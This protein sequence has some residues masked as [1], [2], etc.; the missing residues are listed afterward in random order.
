MVEDKFVQALILTEFDLKKGAVVRF[1]YPKPL[2]GVN[3]ELLASYMMPDGV[4]NKKSDVIYFMLNRRPFKDLK[5]HLPA[6]KSASPSQPVDLAA[7]AGIAQVR[8][9]F[10]PV[11]VYSLF[12]QTNGKLRRMCRVAHAWK[13]D[14]G[15][16]RKQGCEE[17]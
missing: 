10:I 16:G 17:V 15:A 14:I 8:D 6:A 4:H 13:W 3:P 5:L 9:R 2:D 7:A 1:Q 11:N 12:S